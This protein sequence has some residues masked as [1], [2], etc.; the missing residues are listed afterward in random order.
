MLSLPRVRRL[1]VPAALALSLGLPASAVARQGTTI[2]G[3][4]TDSVTLQP[5]A[6]A[7]VVVEELRREVKADAAAR[8]VIE[9]VPPGTYHLSVRAPGYSGRRTE[10]V[11]GASPVAADLAIDPE[12]HYEEAVSVGP[13]ARSQLHEHVRVGGLPDSPLR[14]DGPERQVDLLATFLTE[15]DRT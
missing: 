12:L 5:I 1:V 8:F 4:L 14:G 3:T 9:A 7:V 15:P 6:A 2:T 13:T 10:V 11:V